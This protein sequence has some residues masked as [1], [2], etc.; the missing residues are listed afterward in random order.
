MRRRWHSCRPVRVLPGINALFQV[1]HGGGETFVI[2]S[3]LVVVPRALLLVGA[4]RHALGERTGDRD[5]RGRHWAVRGLQSSLLRNGALNGSCIMQGESEGL[6]P[7]GTT[8]LM[9]GSAPFEWRSLQTWY[10]AKIDCQQ[11]M[12]VCPCQCSGFSPL[13]MLGCCPLCLGSL[14]V[15][16]DITFSG[17]ISSEKARLQIP[18]SRQCNAQT[19]AQ[20]RSSPTEFLECLAS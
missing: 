18:T 20:T 5:V 6:A 1:S 10:S 7:N 2:L 8:Q 12:Y 14:P 4:R 17:Q 9:V 15:F 11:S 13:A 16:V 19:C 3:A